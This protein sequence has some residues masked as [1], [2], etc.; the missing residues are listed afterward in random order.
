MECF[1]WWVWRNPNIAVEAGYAALSE[2]TVSNAGIAATGEYNG[3]F[4]DAKGS[5][6]IN[7]TFSRFVEPG[8]L[9]WN[10]VGFGAASGYSEDG[11]DLTMV[12]VFSACIPINLPVVSNGSSSRM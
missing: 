3:A 1:F 9:F 10:I 5:L 12:W 7:D 11:S 4:I 6:P 2:F 8:T